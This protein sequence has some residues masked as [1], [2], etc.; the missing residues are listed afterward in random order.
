MKTKIYNNQKQLDKDIKDG[1]LELDGDIKI[2][3][4]CK[5]KGDVKANNLTF[6]V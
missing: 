4:N 5:I 6:I 3:F 1:V 2:K